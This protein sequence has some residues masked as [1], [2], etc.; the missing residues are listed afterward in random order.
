MDL[1]TE[2]RLEKFLQLSDLPTVRIDPR[3]EFHLPP[4]HF[5]I[6]YMD[7]RVVLTMSRAIDSPHRDDAFKMLLNRCH[8]V[9]TQGIP[10]RAYMIAERLFLSF[11]PAP[12]HEI[13]H[14]LTCQQTMQR[15][16]ESLHGGE[17]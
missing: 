9:R 6:E 7:S 3:M 2:R 12:E 17:R 15:L 13:K 1:Q 16:L 5:Y 4:L 14:W 10:L 8:P 11:S